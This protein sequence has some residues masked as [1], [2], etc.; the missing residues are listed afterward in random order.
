MSVPV[1]D[2]AAIVALPYAHDEPYGAY[3]RRLAGHADAVA[4][5]RRL[6]SHLDAEL[7]GDERVALWHALWTLHRRLDPA[8]RAQVAAC[9]DGRHA[10]RLAALDLPW[11]APALI[12]HLACATQPAAA[13]AQFVPALLA[14]HGADPLAHPDPARWG[15]YPRLRLLAVRAALWAPPAPLDGEA[16]AN[17]QEA[18][19]SAAADDARGLPL[20]LALLFELALRAGD[21]ASA[22][23]ALADLVHHGQTHWLRP[24]RICAWLDG[25]A[26]ATPAG[27]AAPLQ[28]SPRWQRLWLQPARWHQPARLAALQQAVQRP[29]VCER[30]AWLQARLQVLAGQDPPAAAATPEGDDS[31]APAAPALKVLRALD[32]AYQLLAQGGELGKALPLL[33]GA[34]V[35]APPSL[36]ALHRGQ[37]RWFER[38]APGDT[39]DEA[40][41][42]A[43]LQARRHEADD[44]LRSQI[45]RRLPA[46]ADVPLQLGADWRDEEPYWTA[47]QQRG[48]A[49]QQRLAAFQLASLWTGGGLEPRPPR[50]C[51]H[52]PQAA[53]LWQQLAGHPLYAA[54]A[55]HA[56]QQPEQ[57]LLRPLLRAEDG[58]EHLWI[59]TPGAHG[60]TIVFACVASHHSYPEVALLRGRLPGQHLLFV[61]CPE[62]NWY[63]DQAYDRVHHLIAHSV[64]QRFSPAD[65]SCWYG[66]MGGHGALKF[67]LAFG[68]RAIVFNPQTD[69]D[70]WAAFRPRERPLLWAATRHAG[71]GEWPLGAWEAAPVY[72]ACGASTADREALAW[73]LE[74][75]RRCRHLSVIVEKF[76]DPEHAGL[77][78]RICSAR[79]A[80]ALT[81]ITRRLRQLQGDGPLPGM[82]AVH[83]DGAAAFWQQLDDAKALKLEI[84]VRDGR[85]WW[86][87]SDACGTLPTPDTS[88]AL[89]PV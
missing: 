77:M 68:L 12:E 75:W 17:L 73:V 49:A 48:T 76:D 34:G 42:L 22:A 40:L 43:L 21:G 85:L 8:Q 87:S 59:E 38:Q 74:R 41:L 55:R 78:E 5:Q 86:Q 3:F 47:L 30:L 61:N 67:A 2:A 1:S 51:Q 11:D 72:Y 4:A 58:I 65:V 53:A 89:A 27:D 36:A 39:R 69:L 31:D 50:R 10:K 45:A 20:A 82:Q 63:S 52:L 7:D 81:R 80:P 29:A 19:M 28:L 35:L 37:A 23:T 18:V 26:L 24:E 13:Q 71:L 57:T 62:K 15:R 56:L 46:L 79:V 32:G 33:V 88:A 6:L 70:L 9:L 54:A 60:V 64:L 14:H 83:T 66:S 25:S 44:T 16:I 84:Q